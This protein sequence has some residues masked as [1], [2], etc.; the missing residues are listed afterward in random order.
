MKSFLLLLYNSRISCVLY[1][2]RNES[3]SVSYNILFSINTIFSW[4][5][6]QAGVLY[7][8]RKDE[9]QKLENVEKES[10]RRIK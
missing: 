7:W 4:Y 10:F 6:T 8:I 9:K 1:Q 2:Q 5:K 3:R